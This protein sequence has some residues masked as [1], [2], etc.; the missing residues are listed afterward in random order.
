LLG[1]GLPVNLP[2]PH[3]RLPQFIIFESAQF[4][5]PKVGN[6]LFFVVIIIRAREEKREILHFMIKHGQIKGRND[7]TFFVA[8]YLIRPSNLFD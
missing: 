4:R 5:P 2:R 3:Q 7:K 6:E 1:L 8:A